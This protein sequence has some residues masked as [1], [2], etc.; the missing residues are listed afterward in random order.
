VNFCSLCNRDFASIKA[1]DRHRVGIH[2]Y[3][4]SEGLNFDPPR[5]GG[6]RCLDEAELRERGFVLD[7]RDRMTIA[8]DA[9]RARLRFAGVAQDAT[10]GAKA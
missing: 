10:R 2:S 3:T 7:R 6:R 5:E 8:A 9:E 1:F 4:Y